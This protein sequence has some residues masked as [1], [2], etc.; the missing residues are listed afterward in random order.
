MK[1]S[2]FWLFNTNSL[3]TELHTDA[4][5]YG[6]ASMFFQINSAG[7]KLHLV[8]CV[9]KRLTDTEQHYHST[10]QELMAMV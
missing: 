3:V 7:T 9:N 4:Y 2:E 6:I 1:E 8:Y 5:A 10:K